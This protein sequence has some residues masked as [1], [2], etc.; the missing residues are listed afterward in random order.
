MDEYSQYTVS[1]LDASII[2]EALGQY[3]AVAFPLSDGEGTSY[4]ILTVRRFH[5]IGISSWGGSPVGRIYVVV[6]RHGSHHFDPKQYE[7]DYM[8]EKLQMKGMD[9]ETITKFWNLM[10]ADTALPTR[11]EKE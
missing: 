6:E 1:P 10:W 11:T 2:R 5:W 8:G 7:G 4:N 9:A 3:G